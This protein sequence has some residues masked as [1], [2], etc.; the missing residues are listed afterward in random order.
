MDRDRDHEQRRRTGRRTNIAVGAGE[1]F[2]RR[3]ARRARHRGWCRDARPRRPPARRRSAAARRTG[4]ALTARPAARASSSRASGRRSNKSAR[5]PSGRT[6]CSSYA[7]GRPGSRRCR[8]PRRCARRLAA[9]AHVVDQRPGAVERRRAEIVLVP[10][11]HVAG[12]IADAA[13]DAFDA[14]VGGL[15][16][17]ASPAAPRRSPLSGSGRARNSPCASL[18]LVEEVGHL[19]REVL[20]HAHVAQRFELQLARPRDHLADAGAA[21]PAR[22]AVHHHGAGAAHADA[23]GEAIGQRGVVLALDLGDHVEH[24]LVLAP[25]HGEGLECA[26]PRRRARSRHPAWRP[27]R[28]PPSSL[29]APEIDRA[30]L[31]GAEDHRFDQQADQDDREQAGEHGRGVEV[32]ARLEDVPADAAGARR[33]AEHQFGGDQR[34]PGEGPADLQAGEDRRETPPGSGSG[35]HSARPSG[36]YC[37]RSCAGSPARCGSRSAC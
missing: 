11:H 36:P 33:H 16:L 15:P 32:V 35:R 7:Y 25:R 13:A 9:V 4:S 3:S 18:P 29:H 37:G 12:R 27:A 34:A 30:C 2:R 17:A 10:G 24:G 23:A 5:S 26:R 19:D 31:D 20:D 1:N 8:T 22:P 14:G 28:L 6:T 21:G